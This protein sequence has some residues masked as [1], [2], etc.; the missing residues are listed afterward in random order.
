MTTGIEKPQIKAFTEAAALMRGERYWDHAG[1]PDEIVEFLEAL[2]GALAE[3]CYQLARYGVLNQAAM[4][5]YR[6]VARIRFPAAIPTS[7]EMI[8]LVPLQKKIE[9]LRA[10][11]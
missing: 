7:A 11:E 5:A 2:G 4:D 1:R 3:V 6:E 9:R 10:G 8:L